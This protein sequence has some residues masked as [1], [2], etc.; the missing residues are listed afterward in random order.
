MGMGIFKPEDMYGRPFTQCWRLY[1]S[2]E[3]LAAPIEQFTVTTS[4]VSYTPRS[5]T[6][7]LTG[8]SIQLNGQTLREAEWPE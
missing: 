1:F 4:A 5:L 3:F 8:R 6:W 2:D 7:V